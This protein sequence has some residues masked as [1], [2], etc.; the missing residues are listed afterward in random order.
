MG[1]ASGLGTW[2]RAFGGTHEL[3]R[4]PS[5]VRSP[6][7]IPDHLNDAVTGLRALDMPFALTFS[8]SNDA[9]GRG[10]PYPEPMEPRGEPPVPLDD[11]VEYDLV[12]RLADFTSGFP[13]PREN[14]IAR[15]RDSRAEV[16][17]ENR[18]ILRLERPDYALDGH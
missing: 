6:Q 5:E 4:K 15:R 8:A 14:S 17:L 13:R 16:S 9:V 18:P 1:S 11:T 10:S 7:F 3:A 2:V 12:L